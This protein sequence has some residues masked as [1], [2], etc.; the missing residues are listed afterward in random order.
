MELTLSG[1]PLDLEYQIIAQLPVEKILQLCDEDPYFNLTC[2]DDY[3]WY[4]VT[5]YHHLGNNRPEHMSWWQYFSLFYHELNNVNRGLAK[6][7]RENKSWL[8]DYYI[9][10]GANSWNVALLASVEV[11]DGIGVSLVKFF[12]ERGA[13][14]TD[15]TLEYAV[16]L[17]NLPV[18]EFLV[19]QGGDKTRALDKAV[20]IGSWLM[21][22][23]LLKWGATSSD[24]LW[25]AIV[26]EHNTLA[27]YLL[28]KGMPGLVECLCNAV[29]TGKR[30][31]VSRVIILADDSFG[32]KEWNIAMLSAV[33]FEQVKLIHYFMSLGANDWN[34][35]LLAAI[36]AHNK[37]LVRLFIVQG[38][39][40]W[41]KGLEV[42][43]KE[44]YSEVEEFC[45]K[46]LG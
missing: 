23:Y 44:G 26:K 7:A 17:E 43:H 2:Q 36:S 25:I 38:A 33:S 19:Q 24:A 12:I 15:Q 40:N 5:H 31:L 8:I 4:W 14:N 27:N 42:A 22:Y 3:F 32:V 20:L 30:E 21:V 29:A 35:G 46:Q 11:R 34:G 39:D 16:Q 18:V 37:H 9:S 1:L 45:S 41:K 6:G 28:K 13:N 10:R